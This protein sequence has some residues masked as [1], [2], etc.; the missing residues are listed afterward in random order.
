MLPIAF[1]K[2]KTLSIYYRL[3]F[4]LPLVWVVSNREMFWYLSGKGFNFFFFFLFL[5]FPNCFLVELPTEITAVSEVR[6][7]TVKWDKKSEESETLWNAVVSPTSFSLCSFLLVLSYSGFWVV[8]EVLL[9]VFWAA[10]TFK[11]EYHPEKDQ[12]SLKDLMIP[13]S[14]N[15]QDVI[16]NRARNFSY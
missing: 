2:G 11:V 7:T 13:N 1:S 4:L 12:G 9:V 8:Y 3:F 5:F 15:D 6:E 16:S 14:L 10:F